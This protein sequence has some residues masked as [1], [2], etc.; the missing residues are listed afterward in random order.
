MRLLSI[1]SAAA[2]AAAAIVVA[3]D[4]SAQRNR[5]QASTVVVVDY[6]R[7]VAD[8]LLGRDMTAKLD[9]VRQQIGTEAQSLAPEQQS[10]EQERQRLAQA[11]RNLSPEQ[12]RNNST[13]APQFERFAQRLQQF[14]VRSQTLEGDLQCSQLIALRDLER[15]ITPVLESTMQ[16]RGAG[17]AIDA[18][19]VSH[20]LPNYDIT[21][22]VIDALNNNAATRTATVAR[23]S[24]RE[25]APQQAQQPQQQPAANQ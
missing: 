5:N 4:A 17:V 19:N 25:C 2:L 13:L 15:Q 20:S 8:T 16:A 11:S 14:Q 6:G 22:T 21:Q 1:F 9:Q 24:V 7:I 10:I 12:I 3:P 18:R 23:H